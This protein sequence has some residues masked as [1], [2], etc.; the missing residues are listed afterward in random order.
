MPLTPP[1][2]RVT[3]WQHE[4][5]VWLSI[6][7]VALVSGCSSP[8]RSDLDSSLPSEGVVVADSSPASQTPSQVAGVVTRTPASPTASSALPGLG[9]THWHTLER[10]EGSLVWG[11]SWP[12][13]LPGDNRGCARSYLEL[14]LSSSTMPSLSSFVPSSG[15]Q[16][17]S[18][19]S[20]RLLSATEQ[21]VEPATEADLLGLSEIGLAGVRNWPIWE[22]IALVIAST[23]IV[24]VLVSRVLD[25]VWWVLGLETKKK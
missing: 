11:A 9:E 15:S 21:S 16:S 2:S 8:S 4:V 7:A 25:L 23:V 12:C 14:D 18:Q 19:A 3:I 24:G 22:R 20:H 10:S 5:T 1:L 6:I 17:S 13:A